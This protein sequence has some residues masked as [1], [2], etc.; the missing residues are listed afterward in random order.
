M[1]NTCKTMMGT[2]FPAL[3]T[4]HG[5]KLVLALQGKLSGLSFGIQILLTPMFATAKFGFV[6]LVR[7]SL[8]GEDVGCLQDE[9]QATNSWNFLMV[10]TMHGVIVGH[11]THQ[12]GM[13]IQFA[14]TNGGS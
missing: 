5:H 8:H 6:P 12:L 10:A 4:I 14:V 9:D 1:R 3:N 13:A 2:F 7:Q 11:N